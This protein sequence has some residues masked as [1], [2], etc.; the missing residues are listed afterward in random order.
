MAVSKGKGDG[1]T[2]ERTGNPYRCK[3]CGSLA[4]RDLYCGPC[5]DKLDTTEDYSLGRK[6]YY[7]HFGNKPEPFSKKGYGIVDK[8]YGIKRKAW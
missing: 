5:R 4:S 2:R 6:E 1:G 7:D 3:V 8:D